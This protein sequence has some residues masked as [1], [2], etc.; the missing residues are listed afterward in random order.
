[1]AIHFILLYGLKLLPLVV[2]C[3]CDVWQCYYCCLGG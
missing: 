2:H 1:M 3:E